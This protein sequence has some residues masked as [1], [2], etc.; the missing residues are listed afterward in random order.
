[1]SPDRFLVDTSVW[2]E[3]LPPGRGGDSLRQRVDEL[4][5]GD[6]VATTGMV[7][8][9]LLGGARSESERVRLG[10]LLS[11]L[12]L[13]PVA[14]EHWDEAAWMGFQLR[15]QGISVPFTDPLIGAVALGGG[16]VVLHRDRHFDLMASHL[17]LKVESYATT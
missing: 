6:Q 3:V 11:A 5:A 13:L 12:H 1:M 17:S 4:L 15:K 2:L 10:R 7:R 16:A 8:L 9:E 14:E